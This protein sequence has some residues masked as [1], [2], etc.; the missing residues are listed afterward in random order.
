L[1]PANR[2]LWPTRQRNESTR[3]QDAWQ[4]ETLER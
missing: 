4:R 1:T 3:N 2:K